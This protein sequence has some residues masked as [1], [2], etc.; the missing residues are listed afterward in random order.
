MDY[1]TIKQIR[2]YEYEKNLMESWGRLFTA[3]DKAREK[4][5]LNQDYD[6]ITIIKK[7]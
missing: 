3:L 2:M 1:K 7:D 5:N 4:T 6:K